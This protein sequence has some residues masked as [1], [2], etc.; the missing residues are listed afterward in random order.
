[1]LVQL[2]KYLG[3]AMSQV[4]FVAH[5]NQCNMHKC[6]YFCLVK[7]VHISICFYILAWGNLHALTE[8]R[9]WTIPLSYVGRSIHF[10][11]LSVLPVQTITATAQDGATAVLQQGDWICLNGTTGEVIKGA[12]TSRMN[13]CF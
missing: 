6:L 8:S 5:K 3:F 4:P 7:S 9:I 12:Y 1:M 13:G 2:L 10:L 11:C